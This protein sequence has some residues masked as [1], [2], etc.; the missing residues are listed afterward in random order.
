MSQSTFIQ[1]FSNN[2]EK[3]FF[4]YRRATNINPSPLFPTTSSAIHVK[5]S[6]G[7]I[8]CFHSKQTSRHFFCIYTSS[9]LLFQLRLIYI[10]ALKLLSNIPKSNTWLTHLTTWSTDLCNMLLMDFLKYILQNN[11]ETTHDA[12]IKKNNLQKKK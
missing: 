7:F 3:T 10:I 4:R 8:F 12:S 11:V 1:I 9:L 2:I 5:T 6:L